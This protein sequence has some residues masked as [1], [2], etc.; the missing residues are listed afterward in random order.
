MKAP[1]DVT[2]YT[3]TWPAA[4]PGVKTTVRIGADGQLLFEDEGGGG[5]GAPG[6]DTS[7]VQFNDGG[8]FG[9]DPG[10]TFDKEN[11]RLLVTRDAIGA[12]QSDA[13]GFALVNTTAAADGAQQYSPATRRRGSGWKTN[14]PAGSQTIDFRD[15]VQTIQGAAAPTGLLLH[16]VSLGGA[17]YADRFA[18][19]T[20]GTIW[21]LAPSGGQCFRIGGGT[22]GAI[23]SLTFPSF[24]VV[25]ASDNGTRW[26]VQISG[27]ALTDHSLFAQGGLFVM[28]GAGADSCVKV[29]AGTAATV[30]TAPGVYLDSTVYYDGDSFASKSA[31]TGGVLRDFRYDG[32]ETHTWGDKVTTTD[33]TAATL[34]SETLG[35]NT[36]HVVEVLWVARRTDAAGRASG[37]RRVTVYRAGGGATITAGGAQVLG[38]DET[39]GAITIG[40]VLFDTSSNDL[41]VR[42]T[43]AAGQSIAWRVHVLKV[44][45]N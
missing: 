18:V 29:K 30:Y 40:S 37:R 12:G 45:A 20:D 44:H 36:V 10:L 25:E 38:T 23:A 28:G 26:K 2:D 24:L 8:A 19:G 9:G 31:A 22:G 17:A 41:R 11:D 7:Q 43:G 42:A 32:V 33:A 6:G 21:G 16:Q 39:D 1:V 14:A 35:D 3:A 15:F 4:L 27:S 13:H 34:W 5:G